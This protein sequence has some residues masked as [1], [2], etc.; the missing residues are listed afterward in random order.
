[1][2]KANSS[3]GAAEIEAA[4]DKRKRILL[5]LPE[6][7]SAVQAAYEQR[8]RVYWEGA[9]L[10]ADSLRAA[11][12]IG[13]WDDDFWLLI[14]IAEQ[15]D[16]IGSL[17]ARAETAEA[18]LATMRREV[19]SAIRV[20]EVLNTETEALAARVATLEALLSQLRFYTTDDFLRDEMDAALTPKQESNQ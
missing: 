13:V 17:T 10:S 15:A 9:D 2:T 5:G 18:G 1:M 16:A 12:D 19:D 11:V 7:S 3:P 20:N 14:T 4:A 6:I 8:D